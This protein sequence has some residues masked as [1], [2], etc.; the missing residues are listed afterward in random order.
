MTEGGAYQNRVEC[1]LDWID[2][3]VSTEFSFSLYRLTLACFSLALTI[4][5]IGHMPSVLSCPAP[6]SL[7]VHPFILSVLYCAVLVVVA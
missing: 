5:A 1:A 4:N 3:K 7:L 6:W 2:L